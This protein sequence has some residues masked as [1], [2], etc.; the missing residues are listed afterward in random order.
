M[1]FQQYPTGMLEALRQ[2]LRPRQA[3][4]DIELPMEPDLPEAP[5]NMPGLPTEPNIGSL[6]PS[7]IAPTLQQNESVYPS[8]YTG[9][10]M[11]GTMSF[12]AGK[13]LGNEAALS[14]LKAAQGD[15]LI[16]G[17][18]SLGPEE[19]SRLASRAPGTTAPGANEYFAREL[20][21]EM[22][23]QAL[24]LAPQRKSQEMIEGSIAGLHPA[25]QV[26]AERT[27][28]RAAMPAMITGQMQLRA[29]Q[30]AAGSRRDVAKAGLAGDIKSSQFGNLNALINAARGIQSKPYMTP[31]DTQM[32]RVLRGLID[33]LQNEY[34]GYGLSE[35]EEE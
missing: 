20:Q 14:G 15:Q 17:L 29:A 31:E 24:F 19:L 28:Q 22:G 3:P 32:L 5:D 9:A 2:S 8:A 26:G 12:P 34:T 23:R 4:Q 30:E 11:R 6:D 16:P 27:A 10:P 33:S 1:P 13:V 18:H 7:R 21:D 25:V 35:F